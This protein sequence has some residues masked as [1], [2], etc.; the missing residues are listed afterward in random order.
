MSFLKKFGV[1]LLKVVGVATG[2][3]PLIA[4]FLPA[5]AQA[6]VADTFSRI[7]AAVATVESIGAAIAPSGTVLTGA[8]KAE[9]IVPLVGQIVQT[10][11]LVSG[12]KI[13]DEAA[14]TAA[15]KTIAG[16]V[17]DLLNALE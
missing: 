3:E 13:K 6:K 14:F 15:C 17:A 7:G 16:G 11:E 1:T 8:Q 5:P 2:F 12:R 9:G 10:S 4:P